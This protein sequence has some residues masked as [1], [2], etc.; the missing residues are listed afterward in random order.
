[1]NPLLPDTSIVHIT[2]TKLLSL[3]LCKEL[4][5]H[6]ECLCLWLILIAKRVRPKNRMQM[7]ISRR[8]PYNISAIWENYR[9][10]RQSFRFKNV[11]RNTG[12][13]RKCF[14][15]IVRYSGLFVWIMTSLARFAIWRPW[16]SWKIQTFHANSSVQTHYSALK[17][18]IGNG[19]KLQF[20]SCL[21][22][23]L[24]LLLI[25]GVWTVE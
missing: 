11:F 7:M 14:R 25:V 2:F 12:R 13:F 22:S 20:L 9:E 16:Q 6:I 1:M 3:T 5:M 23:Y 15:K 18:N 4:D 8:G 24:P 17:S 19:N 21:Q 10:S